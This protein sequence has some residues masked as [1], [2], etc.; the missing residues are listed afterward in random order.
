MAWSIFTTSMASILSKFVAP[1]ALDAVLQYSKMA[2]F[3][4]FRLLH[5]CGLW[6]DICCLVSLDGGKAELRNA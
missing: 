4:I 5:G 6:F 2:P 1:A 3:S